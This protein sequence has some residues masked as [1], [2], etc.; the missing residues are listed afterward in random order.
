MSNSPVRL[1]EQLLLAVKKREHTQSYRS[2]LQQFSI[3]QLDSALD[4]DQKKKAFWINMYNA[5]FQIL[6]SENNIEKPN[7]FTAK[8][9]SIA[10]HMFSLDMIEHGILRRNKL[11]FALGFIS[12][13]FPN[14][15]IK[16]LAVEKLDYRIHFA[17][18]CGAKSC[19]P[20]AFYVEKKIDTQLDVATKSFLL[21]ESS[22]DQEKKLLRTTAL[23]KWFAKDF[24]GPKG[25][26]KIFKSQF[27]MDL[28]G[29]KIKYND[30][31]WEEK[32]DYFVQ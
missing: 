32:L 5:Y 29:F 4:T 3:D 22:I 26:L 28:T 19:P 8:L 6:K 12:N 7:I 30:Y 11:K 14:K 2:T 24:G 21:S 31:F 10:G 1:S 17:L 27:D 25:I 16:R 23:F 20:I 13:P 18:N 15:L 9:C